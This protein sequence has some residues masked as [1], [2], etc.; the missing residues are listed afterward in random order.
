[1]HDHAEE[2][3]RWLHGAHQQ[4]TALAIPM[5]WERLS[6][7]GRL[8]YRFVARQLLDDPPDVLKKALVP[9]GA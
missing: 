7:E 8:R 5:T 9:K 1:M 6:E 4:N 3:A 2:L